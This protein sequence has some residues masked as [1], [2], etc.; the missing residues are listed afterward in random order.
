MK[1]IKQNYINKCNRKVLQVECKIASSR[2]EVQGVYTCS[3]IFA[4]SM[5]CLQYKD[6]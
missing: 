4:Q 2:F 5:K 1:T 6:D 3:C